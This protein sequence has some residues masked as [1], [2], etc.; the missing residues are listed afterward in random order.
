MEQ[1][2]PIKYIVQKYFVNQTGL[3]TVYKCTG[4]VS[5]VVRGEKHM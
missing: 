2:L 5:A 1:K 3:N 4:L